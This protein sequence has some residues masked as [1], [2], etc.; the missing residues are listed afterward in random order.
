M[1]LAN[2]KLQTMICSS[3]SFHYMKRN[4][5]IPIANVNK[6]WGLQYWGMTYNDWDEFLREMR[7]Q[8][9]LQTRMGTIWYAGDCGIPWLAGQI[10]KEYKR[11]DQFITHDFISVYG[12]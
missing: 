11:P 1:K 5:I 4:Y 3:V 6:L 9:L 8:A 7:R 2:Y 10:M 12:C